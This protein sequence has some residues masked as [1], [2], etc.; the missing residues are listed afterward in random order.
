MRFR[1]GRVSFLPCRPASTGPERARPPGAAPMREVS[2]THGRG[3]ACRVLCLFPLSSVRLD[4]SGS[5]TAR[6]VLTSS[7]LSRAEGL[8]F[9]ADLDRSYV[10]GVERGER[11]VSLLNLIRLSKPLAVPFSDLFR[12]YESGS[13]IIE[14]KKARDRG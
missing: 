14:R 4:H 1:N 2:P 7:R 13:R 6:Q 5:Q 3:L 8:G 11:N 9:A 12:D 10:G